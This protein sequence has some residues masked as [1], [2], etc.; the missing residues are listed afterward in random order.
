VLKRLLACL[1]FET[2]DALQNAIKVIIWEEMKPVRLMVYL[3]NR[4]GL[5]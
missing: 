1:H 5:A 3:T 2:L 4:Y